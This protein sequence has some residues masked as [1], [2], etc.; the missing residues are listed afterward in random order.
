MK[1]MWRDEVRY[2]GLK[3]KVFQTFSVK[4]FHLEVGI[5]E[6]TW[7]GYMK[8]EARLVGGVPLRSPIPTLLH[9]TI[10]KPHPNSK[11]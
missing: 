9:I 10:S 5:G 8:L 1:I 4:L 2:F 11:S 3:C 6:K 7:T